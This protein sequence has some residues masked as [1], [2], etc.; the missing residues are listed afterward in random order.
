MRR[1]TVFLGFVS[2]VLFGLAGCG[3]S[4]SSSD[5][6]GGSKQGGGATAGSVA[7]GS[8][9]GGTASGLGGGLGAAGTT[10]GLG[11]S[12]AGGN[13][14]AQTT[15]T[16]A[17]ADAGISHPPDAPIV[18]GSGGNSG[19]GGGRSTGTTA[20]LG[21][22]TGSGGDT[23]TG[24]LPVDAGTV[25]D[26][27]AVCSGPNPAA[28]SCR[29]SASSCVPSACGCVA[30]IGWQCTAD[31]RTS[32]PVCPDGGTTPDT[33]IS[34][35]PCGKTFCSSDESCCNANCSQCAPTGG[36]C[37]AQICQ[38][39][40]SW[41]CASDKD[42]TLVDDYCGGCNCRSFGPRGQLGTCDKGLSECFV[43][44]C[45]MK[46]ARCQDGVCT[47]AAKPTH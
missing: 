23:S 2:V 44:P 21:G 47:A 10:G 32:L 1:S 45:S 24:A 20:P 46:I 26:A 16:L 17:S 33:R 15:G 36:A 31:C 19:T 22:S 3:G 43:A 40:D 14:G 37:T 18:G 12:M 38:P 25:S 30:G 4:G 28:I 29:A 35:V 6:T 8:E 41:A 42:C 11:G 39:P 7:L 5:G 9:G 13:G 34:G 27:A